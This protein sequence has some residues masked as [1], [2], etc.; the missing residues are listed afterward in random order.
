MSDNN[1]TENQVETLNP[2]HVKSPGIS[3]LY[4]ILVEKHLGKKKAQ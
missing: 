3:T 1:G 4:D 2:Q